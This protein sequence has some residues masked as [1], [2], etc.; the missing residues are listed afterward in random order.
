MNARRRPGRALVL[1]LVFSGVGQAQTGKAQVAPPPTPASVELARLGFVEG[2]VEIQRPGGA[3][4]K[5]VENQSLSGGDR[6]RTLRGGTA[7][8]EF[9]WTDIAMSDG[10]EV[11]LQNNRVLT[12]R[13]D[14]GR[15][16]IDPEQTLLRV[17]TDEAA[18]SGAGRTV[19]RREGQST[20]VGS[21]YGGA[22]V[23]AKGVSLRLGVN[24]GALARAGA[25]PE[26]V[27]MGPPPRV[28]SPAANPRYV[29]PGQPVRLVWAGPEPAYH[30]DVL[31]IDSDVPVL[32]LD[33]DARTFDL[34]LDWLG[35]FRWRVSGRSG[36][37]ESQPS[38]EGLICVVEK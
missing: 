28:I 16:D 24:R 17:I 3:W 38:G 1:L 30:L 20:F 31:S 25:P 6:V 32:S 27:A 8:L 4:T 29:K 10:S 37:A 2:G 36:I 5:A 26:P 33:I 14:H 22:E 21:Y 34:R 7:R 23:E 35:T 11:S 9:P 18:V 13:L 12:V 19:V 15:I